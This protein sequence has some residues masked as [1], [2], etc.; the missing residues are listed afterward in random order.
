MEQT[1]EQ[2][3]KEIM[4]ILYKKSQQKPIW[5]TCSEIFWNIQ[6]IKVSERSVAEVLDWLVKN[7]AVIHQADK[8]QISKREFLEMSERKRIEQEEVNQSGNNATDR[9][10]HEVASLLKDRNDIPERPRNA[11][12]FYTAIALIAFLLSGIFIGIL[13]FNHYAQS[14]ESVT[15]QSTEI[16]DSIQIKN[17]EVRVMGYVEDAYTINRN[18]RNLSRSLSEQQEVNKEILS[19]FRSQQ[20][21]INTLIAYNKHQSEIIVQK[22][23]ELSVYLWIIGLAVLTGSI[24]LIAWYG[25]R[26]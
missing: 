15:M 14:K 19:L 20:E 16:P 9:S 17:L 7:E 24:L 12:I 3:Q 18:F 10:I 5:V 11:N 21:Q 22:E 1:K 2:L 4:E 26:N 23:K 13:L 6:N 8:Y 25:K